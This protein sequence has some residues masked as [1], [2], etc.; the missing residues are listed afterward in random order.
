M[1]E[2]TLPEEPCSPS[3]P[4][5]PPAKRQRTASSAAETP[6]SSHQQAHHG[7]HIQQTGGKTVLNMA[8]LG[9]LH[10]ESAHH[11]HMPT[12]PQPLN[13]PT[14]PVDE[15]LARRSY[16]DST[17]PYQASE[18]RKSWSMEQ[19]HPSLTASSKLDMGACRQF[20]LQDYSEACLFKYYIDEVAPWV[21]DTSLCHA[22]YG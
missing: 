1:C 2:P 6:V 10:H 14:P 13:P 11:D 21:G 12:H 3:L 18:S 22:C 19:S 16:G 20:P 5:P 15:S 9:C 4:E 8:C 7:P 17:S